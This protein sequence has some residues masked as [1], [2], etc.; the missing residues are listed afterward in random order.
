[1]VVRERGAPSS[2]CSTASITFERRCLSAL[3][4]ALNHQVCGRAS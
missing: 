3:P 1:M 2:Q 4:G